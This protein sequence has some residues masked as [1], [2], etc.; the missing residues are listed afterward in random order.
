MS[1]DDRDDSARNPNLSESPSAGNRVFGL[2]LMGITFVADDFDA[3]DP[4][5]VALFEG[6]DDDDDE[7]FS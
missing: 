2:K 7:L 5:I 1:I 3:V 6:S 4:E